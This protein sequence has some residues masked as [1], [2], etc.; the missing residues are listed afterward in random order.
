MSKEMKPGTL[1]THFHKMFYY[2]LIVPL[3]IILISLFKALNV[4]IWKDK[5]ELISNSLP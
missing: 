5:L 3:Y 4:C 2:F 1:I